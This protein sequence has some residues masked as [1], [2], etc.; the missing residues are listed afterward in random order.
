MLQEEHIRVQP[1]IQKPAW[2]SVK[3]S[4]QAFLDY[5]P[6][7]HK[8]MSGLLGLTSLHLD[9]LMSASAVCQWQW[10]HA[11]KWTYKI[12][13]FFLFLFFFILFCFFLII[14]S[15][16]Y[17]NVN[18]GVFWCWRCV[19]FLFLFLLSVFPLYIL[20]QFPKFCIIFLCPQAWPPISSSSS[21][22]LFL[23]LI[24]FKFFLLR[25]KLLYQRLI[26]CI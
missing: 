12:F 15:C 3:L 20:H 19:P 26:Y 7:H 10:R 14:G 13:Y 17:M 23:P 16:F 5:P 22:P 24:P 9:Q 2:T 25:V 1:Y 8:S 11:L 18:I 21:I 6:T 4:V